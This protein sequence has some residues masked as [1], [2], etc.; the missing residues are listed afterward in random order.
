MALRNTAGYMGLYG[1]VSLEKSYCLKCKG[2]FLVK[3]GILQCCDER[4]YARPEKWK[5]ESLATGD[6][7][8]PSVSYQKDQLRL[9]E[10]RCFYCERVFG[11]KVAYRD[12]VVILRIHWDHFVPYAYLQSSPDRNFVAACQICNSIKSS[13]CFQ[14]TEEARTYVSAIRDRRTAEAKAV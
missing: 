6:R 12:K 5:R 9:Q 3:K 2:F 10:N 1:G 11:F 4:V 13:K 8:K 14:T 7:S